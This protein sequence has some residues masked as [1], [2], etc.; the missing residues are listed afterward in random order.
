LDFPLEERAFLGQA[1]AAILI[2]ATAR[3]S[4]TAEYR[5]DALR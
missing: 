2:A 5:A 1:G 3:R 4:A